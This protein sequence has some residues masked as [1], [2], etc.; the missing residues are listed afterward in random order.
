MNREDDL[1]EIENELKAEPFIDRPREFDEVAGMLCWLDGSRVCGA[2]CVAFNPE[3]L[4]PHGEV[5]QGPMKCLPLTYMGQQGSAAIV[6]IQAARRRMKQEQDAVREN[7]PP[8][9]DPF[10][11]R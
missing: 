9:P 11:G 4:G 6:T 3:E 8:P 7:Q 10:G 1:D 2:D 5:L